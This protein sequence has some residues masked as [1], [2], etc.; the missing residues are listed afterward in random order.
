MRPI[1]FDQLDSAIRGRP[2]SG[3]D[4]FV[5]DCEGESLPAVELDASEQQRCSR[6]ATPLLRQRFRACHIAKRAVL[7][8]YLEQD[9]DALLFVHGRFGKPLLAGGALHFNLSHS[10]QWMMLAVADAEIGIDCERVDAGL[11]LIA[12][13]PTV[14]HRDEC[15][16][17]RGGFFRV[18]VRK[19][20]VLKQLGLG[21]QLPPARVCVPDAADRLDGWH[22]VRADDA[23]MPLVLDLP[24]PEGFVAALSAT[25]PAPIRV[26]HLLAER[27]CEL[28]A[29]T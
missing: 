22:T 21:F 29:M 9:P 27:E 2:R 20:A 24:A 11:D 5:F 25:A 8:S 23:A 26:F 17:D 7:A 18:W 3:V 19:E 16:T 1:G 10:R 13:L 4:V 15:I 6:F 28:N 14:A 12:L